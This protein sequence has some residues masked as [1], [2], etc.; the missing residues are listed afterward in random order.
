[1]QQGNR[2][3]CNCCGR[4][5]CI[6]IGKNM[7]EYFHLRKSWGYFSRKDGITQTADICE[8]CMDQWM[9]RFQIP[10]ERVER[11]ELFEC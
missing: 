1:M 3:F 9:Q 4:E 11:T 8:S 7:E 5:I 10:P 6:E 2:L